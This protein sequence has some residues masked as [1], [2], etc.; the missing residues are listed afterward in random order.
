MIPIEYDIII[1]KEDETY[2]AYC[3]EL[4]ISSCG[5]TVEHS[6]E[7]LK[8]AVKL[9]LEEAEKMGTLEDILEESRY[10]KDASGRW[11]P[12]KLVATEFVSMP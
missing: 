12:P 9:F 11:S 4:D 10:K 7:M 6:K 3:P 8:T 1:F 5:N 2:V